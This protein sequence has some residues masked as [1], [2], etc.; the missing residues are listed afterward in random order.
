MRSYACFI[1][2]SGKLN[3]K[4]CKYIYIDDRA[5]STNDASQSIIYSLP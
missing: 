5:L 1:E 2:C 3:A 4:E